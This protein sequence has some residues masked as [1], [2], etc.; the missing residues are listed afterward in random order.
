MKSLYLPFLRVTAV[1]C[2]ITCLVFL[3]CGGGDGGDATGP[4]SEPEILAS[5]EITAPE[6]S[7]LETNG[8][9]T[10]IQNLFYFFSYFYG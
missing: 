5:F 2:L 4:D 10:V 3:G 1:G 7:H 6:T 9:N 8:P